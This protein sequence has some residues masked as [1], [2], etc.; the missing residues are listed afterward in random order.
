MLSASALVL[1]ALSSSPPSTPPQVT[2]DEYTQADG[3]RVRWAA[4][5]YALP[6]GEAAEVFLAVDDTQSGDGYLMVEG[7]TIVHVSYDDHGGTTT[8]VAPGTT[9]DATLFGLPGVADELLDALADTGGPQEFKCSGFGEGV[10]KAGKYIWLGMV[11]AGAAACCVL[12][13]GGACVV[14]GAAGMA[15]G[16]LG[17][18]LAEGYCA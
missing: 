11:G 16:E 3:R 6:T 14:C 4:V 7:E 9:G 2:A 12:S 13:S 8:W 10:L 15:A 18:D 17:S 5:T 1:L